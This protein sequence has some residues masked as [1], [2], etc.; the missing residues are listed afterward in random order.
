MND[1]FRSFQIGLRL[2]SLRMPFKQAL[3]MAAHLGADAV[4]I[5]ARDQVKPSTLSGT[6]LR[7]LRKLLDDLRLKVSAVSFPTRRGDHVA[8]D[9]ERRVTATKLAMDMAYSIGAR[10]VTNHIGYIEPTEA[11]KDQPADPSQTMLREALLDIGKHG[12][13]CGAFLAA[14]TGNDDPKVLTR[15]IESLPT[16][17]LFVDFDPGNLIVNGFS[18]SDALSRLVAYT[19][20]VHA[21]DGVRDLAR[22][23]GLEVPLGQGSVDWCEILAMLEQHRYTGYLTVERNE[24]PNP[25]SELGDAIAYLREIQR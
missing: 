20:H 6:G 7:Q 2:D 12:Q 17:F 25:R 21:R 13:H 8:D 5:N 16:G 23:R 22:G 15:F 19:I 9:L 3:K 1:S 4:E 11:S 10:V 24:S 14:S 18:A